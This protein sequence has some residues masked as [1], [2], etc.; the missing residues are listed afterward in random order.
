M[1]LVRYKANIAVFRKD[2]EKNMRSVNF[3]PHP[4]YGP[5]LGGADTKTRPENKNLC[6]M[7]HPW[8]GGYQNPPKTLPENENLPFKIL[9]SESTRETPIKK[10]P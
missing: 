9:F 4:R 1:A 10:Y 5:P 6:L 3:V 8:A 7:G 2:S